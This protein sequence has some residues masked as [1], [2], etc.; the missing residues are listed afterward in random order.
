MRIVRI[1]PFALTAVVSCA[2]KQ[3]VPEFVLPPGVV[4]DIECTSRRGEYPWI[5]ITADVVYFGTS[6]GVDAFA[7]QDRSREG[8]NTVVRWKTDVETM[9]KL[10]IDPNG[11]STLSNYEPVTTDYL[12]CFAPR[13]G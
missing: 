5:A 8:R 11:R 4:A 7:I 10:T 13:P 1:L 6:I 12:T 2:D 3:T 9:S